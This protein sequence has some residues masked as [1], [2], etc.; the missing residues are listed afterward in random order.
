MLPER[1]APPAVADV[2]VDEKRVHTISFPTVESH[3][4]NFSETS[5]RT[6]TLRASYALLTKETQ[7]LLF[8]QVVD[9]P[10]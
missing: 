6:S 3:L 5:T 9:F 4:N 7:P 8:T 2:V 10:F 1:R